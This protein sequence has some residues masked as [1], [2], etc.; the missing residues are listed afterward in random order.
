MATNGEP[1]GLNT[2]P[3]PF[4]FI[5]QLGQQLANSFQ[6]FP[7]DLELFAFDRAASSNAGFQSRQQRGQIISPRRQS[8]NDRHCLS[9]F[10]LLNR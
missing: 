1:S 3:L 2:S 7:L 6:M 9:L 10:A 4:H 5:P 8:L